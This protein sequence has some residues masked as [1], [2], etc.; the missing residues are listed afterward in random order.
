MRIDVQPSALRDLREGF[1][2]YEGQETGLGA[3]FLD[4]LFSDIDSLQLFAG[5]H[6]IHFTRFYRLLSK[7]FP[8]AIYY[9]LEDHTAL[10][11]AVLD[12]R[13][14]PKWIERKLKG[15]F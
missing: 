15:L 10:V 12:L 1:R 13:R 7:R 4:S 11:R 9:Q 3:Y 5:I 8:Y 6:S 14:D 2:F